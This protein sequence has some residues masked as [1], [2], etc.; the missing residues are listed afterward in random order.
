MRFAI[1]AGLRSCG[2]AKPLK[3]L[4][5]CGLASAGSRRRNYGSTGGK[6]ANPEGA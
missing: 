1:G 2:A 3:I 4:A 6:S 5:R